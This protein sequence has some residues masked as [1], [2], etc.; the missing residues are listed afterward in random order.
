MQPINQ[1]RCLYLLSAIV[2]VELMFYCLRWFGE[3]AGFAISLP[4]ALVFTFAAIHLPFWY[5]DRK[6]RLLKERAEQA[7]I[8][9]KGI[10]R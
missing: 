4:I 3:A 9:N 1:A 5:Q 6:E 8:A 7:L 10:Y 2:Q